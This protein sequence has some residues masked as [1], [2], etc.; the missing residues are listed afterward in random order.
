MLNE[1]AHRSQK[2]CSTVG[3]GA[4]SKRYI[5]DWLP[6][7]RIEYGW[8]NLPVY[9]R[10]QKPS[11]QLALNRIRYINDWLPSLRIQYGGA[12]DRCVSGLNMV[13]EPPG[14]LTTDSRL[15]LVHYLYLGKGRHFR[16]S[17]FIIIHL[18]I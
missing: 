15:L 8:G 6:S 13:D 7:L 3:A 12:I 4:V 1:L 10:Y 18:S 2:P 11:R 9:L 16:S 17:F 14:I 5:N